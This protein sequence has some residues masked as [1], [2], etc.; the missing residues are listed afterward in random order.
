MNDRDKSILWAREVISHPDEYLILDTET[1][2]L[3]WGSEIVQ[4]SIIDGHGNPLINTLVRPVYPIPA[5]AMAIHGIT[6]EM[7]SIAQPWPAI[8]PIVKKIMQGKKVIIYNATY[9]ITMISSSCA[10][11]KM[12]IP[13][14]APYQVAC[15]MHKYAAYVGDWDS[16]RGSYRWKKLPSGDHSAMGDV[17]ATLDLIRMMAETPMTTGGSHA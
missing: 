9:D 12:D 11:S 8:W 2:G 4:I 16:R 5:D 10:Q 15:A 17:K 7:V 6:N 1:T 3:G 14:M 13:N